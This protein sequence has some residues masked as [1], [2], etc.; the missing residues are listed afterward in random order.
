MVNFYMTGTSVVVSYDEKRPFVI[1]ND[2]VTYLTTRPVQ[3]GQ[4]AF[5]LKVGEKVYNDP[6][7]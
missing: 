3:P 6:R 1:R 5:K 2:G 7:R 4:F